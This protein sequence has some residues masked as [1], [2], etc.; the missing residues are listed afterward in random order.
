M[1][2]N[3]IK[4]VNYINANTSNSLRN[5]SLFEMYFH[6]KCFVYDN[7]FRELLLGFEIICYKKS[8]PLPK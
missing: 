5:I 8:F 6:C 1:I 2:K 3:K 4:D 7:M